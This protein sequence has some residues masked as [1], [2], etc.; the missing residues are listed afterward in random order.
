M[1][2]PWLAEHQKWWKMDGPWS[3]EEP[4][5]SRLPELFAQAVRQKVDD[6]LNE[7]PE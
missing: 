2:A 7:T 6:L 3:E 4:P 5:P 1:W